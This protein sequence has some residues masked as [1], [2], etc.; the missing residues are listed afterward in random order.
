MGDVMRIRVGF[1]SLLL[2]SATVFAQDA[3]AKCVADF[4]GPVPR[5]GCKVRARPVAAPVII[6]PNYEDP[7]FQQAHVYY[8]G[9]IYRPPGALLGA[10][11]PCLWMLALT[12]TN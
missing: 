6:L 3:A 9:C 11:I 1:A 10:C 8:A 7:R 2:V 4:D 12:D 5:S